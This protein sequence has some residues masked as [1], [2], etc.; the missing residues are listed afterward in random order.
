MTACVALSN[1]LPNDAGG[2]ESW[3]SAKEWLCFMLPPEDWGWTGG[4]WRKDEREARLLGLL[5]A[6]AMAEEAGD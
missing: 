3:H 1:V 4:W 5:F 2:N 6:S